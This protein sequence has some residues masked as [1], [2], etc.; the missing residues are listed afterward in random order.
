MNDE[1]TWPWRAS[2]CQEDVDVCLG[3]VAI[4]RIVR[5]PGGSLESVSHR[6]AAARRMVAALNAV[7]HLTTEEL[8]R[9][10]L[11]GGER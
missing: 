11:S 5:P 8:E 6:L 2:L 7:K 10:M 4:A 1:Q 9:G 3:D